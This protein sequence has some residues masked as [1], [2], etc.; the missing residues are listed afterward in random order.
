LARGRRWGDGGVVT[1]LR[2]VTLDPANELEP[3]SFY[4]TNTP[5]TPAGPE[6]SEEGQ[7]KMRAEVLDEHETVRARG[8]VEILPGSRVGFLGWRGFVRLD[9]P[10]GEL[11][12]GRYTLR[13]ATG[14][15]GVM[16]RR[17]ISG[18]WASQGLTLPLVGISEAPPPANDPMAA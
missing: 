7:I 4:E 16:V 11:A 2:L 9:G 14:E 13:T 17:V 6:R 1:H 15:Y 3:A 8:V 10:C 18:G 12:P 5:S